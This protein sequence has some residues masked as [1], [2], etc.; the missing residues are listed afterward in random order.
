MLQADPRERIMGLTPKFLRSTMR[1]NMRPERL[2]AL[3]PLLFAAALVVTSQAAA[4]NSAPL[5]P[6]DP[7]VS[8]PATDPT[9]AP[10]RRTPPSLLT[11]VDPQFSEQA[12][13]AKFSGVVLVNLIVDANGL[14]RNVHVLRGV[15]MGL[16]E[17]AVAAVKQY[18]FRPAMEGGKPVAVELNVEVNF[19]VF[20]SPKIV[21][22]A[23]LELT[24]EVRRNHASGTILLAFIV[25]TRGNPQNVHV[26]QGVGMGM[27]ENAVEAVKHYKFE[28]FLK[29]GQPIAQQATLQLKFDAK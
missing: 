13:K 24:D 12:R 17:S 22:A 18:T 3:A 5:S 28:P 8:A 2:P 6:T 19:Q 16:D 15:G 11:K 21:R 27:D 25:D 10:L 23:Q 29:D 4:Q 9:L 26:L 1:P 20:E 7:A 14:P